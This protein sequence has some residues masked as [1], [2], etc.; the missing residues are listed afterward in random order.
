MP[1]YNHFYLCCKTDTPEV[2]IITEPNW[3]PLEF[4]C[5]LPSVVLQAGEK[6][7]QL[8]PSPALCIFFLTSLFIVIIQIIT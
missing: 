8:H 6:A 7:V 3:Q 5:Y 1:L 4:V 2:T